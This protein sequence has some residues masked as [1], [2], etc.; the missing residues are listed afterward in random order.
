MRSI[1]TYRTILQ[2]K[3]LR[4][5]IQEGWRAV[6]PL[7]CTRDK[8]VKDLIHSQRVERYLRRYLQFATDYPEPSVSVPPIIWICWL[9]GMEQA[10]LLVQQCYA[11]VLR[12]AEGF[13]VRLITAENMFDYVQIDPR[14]VEKYRAGRIPFAQFSDILRVALLAEHGGIWMDATVAMTG[15]MP[16]YVTR[17]SLFMFRTSLLQQMP[18][19]ASNWFLAACPHHPLMLNMRELLT[20]YWLHESHL[21]DY[22][23]FHILLYILVREHAQSQRLFRAMPY[24]PNVDVHTMMYRA[25]EPFSEAL[26]ADILSR[27]TIH[28]LSYK[29]DIDYS[30]YIQ[31]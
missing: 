4:Y 12:Y 31:S 18:T 28:K 7:W 13:E 26:K 3:G 23:I 29:N 30:L 21:R 6:W 5:A 24:V 8:A 16:D 25:A 20:Q 1:S 15:A 27:S 2:K 9:Q 10:P 17:G 14:V 22:Y 19:A 11:S